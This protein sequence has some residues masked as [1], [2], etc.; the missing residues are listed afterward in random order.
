MAVFPLMSRYARNSNNNLL[1][2]YVL[3]L[4]LLVLVS[5]PIAMTVTALAEPLV[6]LVG[7]AQYLNVP[8]SF[9]LFGREFYYMGG[10][11]VALRFI[12]WSIPIGF[13]N[14]V[15]QYV[16][17]AVNQQHYLTRAFIMGVIFNVVGNLLV[18]PNFGYVGAAVVTILSEFCLLLP[19]YASVRV[20]VGVVP[21]VSIFMRPIL[22][23]AAMGLTIYALTH[24]GVN[25]WLATGIGVGVY[26]VALWL[27]GAL[28]G[29]EM[30]VLR[31]AL[32]KGSTPP[33][34]S[35]LEGGD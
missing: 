27:L 25:L 32:M 14:S 2:T 18:I 30:M 10:S 28:H 16:L 22:A 35:V 8:E 19:F 34:G 23:T 29:E 17:I 11:D 6:W 21:W 26:G 12:I 4:R 31:R 15:T 3:S 33:A 7:G 24:V 20:H 13:V 9:T 5:L 1:R